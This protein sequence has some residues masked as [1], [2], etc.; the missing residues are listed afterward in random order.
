MIAAVYRIGPT[1]LLLLL[2][3]VAI[4]AFVIRKMAGKK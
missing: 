4:A 1:E 3:V 2:V